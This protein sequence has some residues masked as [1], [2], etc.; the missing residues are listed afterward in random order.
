MKISKLLKIIGGISIVVIV[1]NI[2]A[3]LGLN[4]AINQEREAKEKQI[5]FEH[6]G[7]ELKKASDYL[8]EQTKN[9][10]LL[11]EKV[12]YD[13]YWKEVNETRTREKVLVKLEE[14]GATE[15][16]IQI[17][18]KAENASKDLAKVEERALDIVLIGNM[19]EAR[20]LIF[21]SSYN[22]AKAGIDKLV[23]EFI[24]E[25]NT[26]ARI[27]AE[28]A[29]NKAKLQFIIVYI[30]MALLITI[31][32]LTFM[33]LLKKIKGLITI[34]KQLEELATN[35]GDLT[36]RVDINSK[37]EVGDIAN[38]FNIFVEKVR[39][40]VVEIADISQQ[41]AASSEELNSTTEQSSVAAEEVARAID[42]IAK[43]A[44]DQAKDTEDG[45]IHINDLGIFIEKSS[46]LIENLNES[47]DEV[48]KLIEEGFESIKVLNTSAEDN[49]KISISVGKTIMETN[50]SA[51][52]ISVASD[53]IRNIAE[54]TNLLAL[55]AAIEAARAG[56]SGRGFSVVAEEIKKLAEQ[57]T[58]FA[59][60]I[61]EVIKDLIQKTEHSVMLMEEA[62]K[63]VNS[64]STSVVD[65]SN[66]FKGI[67]EFIQKMK[68]SI[69]II[70]ES[71]QEM[72][73]RKDEVINIMETLSAISEEN[74]AGTQ[75]ASASIEEQTASME[76]IANA[77]EELAKQAE[78]IL[79][80]IGRFKY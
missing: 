4:S 63:I 43:G 28:S 22:D 73:I 67:S 80:S 70:N 9:Y 53:M 20:E 74:A 69:E 42:E 34:T 8:T 62:E 61:T 66:K 37:D 16:Q 10:V 57:S 33:V 68:D 44:T 29:L 5:E 26:M 48:I 40:I 75:E 14:L 39:N 55:N 2:M 56:E 35:D 15:E 1:V 45:S 3:L 77:S 25:I 54:Q 7:L 32:I 6:L 58:G 17:L 36:S 19:E 72:S 50:T 60:E 24:E 21:S 38:S 47:S 71:T 23:N 12:Y 46:E 30:L 18:D 65:T 13:N 41:V 52:K 59:N 78:S 51:E 79:K 49:N 11:G 27:N 64:Q 76:E 31:I